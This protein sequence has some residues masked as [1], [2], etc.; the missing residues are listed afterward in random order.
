MSALFT[1]AYAMGRFTMEVIAEML[2]I[3]SEPKQGFRQFFTTKETDTYGIQYDV[4]RNNDRVALDVAIYEKG[5]I[6]RRDKGTQKN[7]VPANF[8]EKFDYSALEEY[9]NIQGANGGVAEKPYN[10]LIKNTAEGVRDIDDAFDMAEELACASVMLTGEFPIRK[11]TTIDFKR[12]AASILAYDAGR[13]FGIDTVNPEETFILAGDFLVNEGDAAASEIFTAI[14]GPKVWL[15]MKNNPIVQKQADIRRMDHMELTTGSEN[16]TAPMESLTPQ[17]VYSAGSYTFRI[18][19]YGGTYKDE[20]G[21]THGIM[22]TNAMVVIPSSYDFD[23]TYCA[24]KAMQGKVGSRWPKLIKG[25]RSTYK[26]ENEEEC[27]VQIGRRS[28][29]APVPRSID[30]IWTATILQ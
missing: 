24:T 18:W 9:E 13:D 14:L 17:G 22:D 4:V 19:T 26:I 20:S 6:V 29:F 5:R 2:N 21:V 8:D 15:K 7:L 16:N 11:G 23:F 28:R 27:N 1:L 12:K 10:Q 3:K 30:K 25:K